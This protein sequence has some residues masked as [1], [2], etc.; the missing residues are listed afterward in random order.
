MRGHLRVVLEPQRR[1]RATKGLKMRTRHW[2][3]SL[4]PLYSRQLF[5]QHSASCHLVCAYPRR[6]A[7]NNAKLLEQPKQSSPASEPD[8]V[9][10]TLQRHALFVSRSQPPRLAPTANPSRHPANLACRFHPGASAHP[11]RHHRKR[12]AAFRTRNPA[13][14]QWRRATAWR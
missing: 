2:R 7:R 14:A 5:E 9:K 1:I 10:E 11:R 3:V 8:I 4:F 6:F 12:M 13:A